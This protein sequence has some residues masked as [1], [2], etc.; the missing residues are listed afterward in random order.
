MAVVL[1]AL[2]SA[3]GAVVTGSVLST[4]QAMI[5]TADAETLASTAL[6]AL[7][8]EVRFG[9]NITQKP[10]AAVG[11]YPQVEKIDSQI[12][13]PEAEFSVDGGKIKVKSMTKT[14]DLLSESAYSHLK[15]AG[16]SMEIIGGQVK[17]SLTVSGRSGKELWSGGMTVSPMNSI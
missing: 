17:I 15:I 14:F 5:E 9:R 7:A 8:N 2:M 11:G 13:G 4:R 3:A 16:M 10:G 1:L 12:F 6:E